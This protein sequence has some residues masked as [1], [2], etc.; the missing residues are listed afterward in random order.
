MADTMPKV[1]VSVRSLL[2]ACLVLCAGVPA[3]RAVELPALGIA[4]PVPSAGGEKNA[5]FTIGGVALPTPVQGPAPELLAAQAPSSQ[6][7]I[8]S[9][10]AEVAQGVLPESSLR[11]PAAPLRLPRPLKQPPILMQV[12]ATMAG[13]VTRVMPR[14]AVPAGAAAPSAA[15]GTLEMPAAVGVVSNTTVGLSLAAAAAASEAGTSVR[16][17]EAANGSVLVPRDS[18]VA[19][20]G[21]PSAGAA[22]PTTG[23]DG[24]ADPVG[25]STSP[26][27]VSEDEAAPEDEASWGRA[28]PLVALQDGGAA[29]VD[30]V[31]RPMLGPSVADPMPQAQQEAASELLGAV[32]DD[33][34]KSAEAPLVQPAVLTVPASFAAA[35]LPELHGDQSSGQQDDSTVDIS[36][37]S[38][39]NVVAEGPRALG[40]TPFWRWWLAVVL[41]LTLAG[42]LCWPRWRQPANNG[43]AAEVRRLR[44]SSSIEIHSMFALGMV[45]DIPRVPSSLGILMRVQGK[46][47]ARP[48]G[49]FAAPFS[50][51]P[52]VYYAASVS[53][54]RHDG[55]HPPPL[56]YHSAGSDFALQ[57]CGAPQVI[58]TVR[59][60][61][62]ALFDMIS[63]MQEW[64]Q[65]FS[66]APAP[67]RSFVMDH[68]VPSADATAHFGACANL[69][70][71]GGPLEFRESALL[72]GRNVTCIGEVSRDPSGSL[73]L[74]PWRP[75]A[76]VPLPPHLAEP[77][78]SWLSILAPCLGRAIPV[79]AALPPLADAL[80]GRVLLSDDPALLGAAAKLPQAMLWLP[81][82]LTGRLSRLQQDLGRRCWSEPAL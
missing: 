5:Q 37:K 8:I 27:L 34:A 11:P 69:S 82:A 78:P 66:R 73:V 3:G 75:Q 63:G 29:A 39:D 7:A 10:A 42:M 64:K 45:A 48:D 60:H 36:G 18:L 47:V 20:P 19:G 58:L 62:L 53:H 49:L 55:V 26:D 70:P 59:G 33:L 23:A 51:G 2:V 12:R 30:A 43:V 1:S 41:I 31:S 32:A 65:A 6:A 15:S 72:T 4:V 40:N 22:A 25:S 76:E 38:G 80:A 28:A 67:W 16:F 56:A 79:H 81:A 44:V 24:S 9:A 74:Q 21:A 71:M 57:L 46:V 13:S 54:P 68:L 17:V 61:D 14:L 35:L 52:C 50:G 77:S